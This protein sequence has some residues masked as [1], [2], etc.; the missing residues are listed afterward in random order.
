MGFAELKKLAQDAEE[1]PQAP[2]SDARKT[3]LAAQQFLKHHGPL[4]RAFVSSGT[5]PLGFE[6]SEE[7][8]AMAEQSR[9]LAI[10]IT[11]SVTG[12]KADEVTLEE[13]RNFRLEA[14]DIVAEAWRTGRPIDI[15]GTAR[16]VGAAIS[17]ANPVYDAENIFWGQIT[18]SG[19]L[20]MTA[21]GVGASLFKA[22]HAY[23]FRLGAKVVLAA[24]TGAIVEATMRAVHDITREG[25]TREDRRSLTQTTMRTYA[26]MMAEIYEVETRHTLEAAVHVPKSE[27]GA[28][29]E[30]RAPLQRV[31][32]AFETWSSVLTEV[33]LN[34]A[35]E[36]IATLEATSPAAAPGP[37][38]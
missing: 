17:F 34:A 33:T 25:A 35:T 4:L 18:G 2:A 14:A 29:L 23:D 24:L 7:F 6:G 1:R 38:N 15:E 13:A 10:A 31:L 36:A 3:R 9:Q 26:G 37:V 32:S 8:R 28:W 27:R 19:S 30:Q 22:V 16:A 12:K 20:A 21:A 11:A 5:A